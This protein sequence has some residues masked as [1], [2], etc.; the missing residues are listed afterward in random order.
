MH[1][2][3]VF[4]RALVQMNA[5]IKLTKEKCWHSRIDLNWKDRV[6]EGRKKLGDQFKKKKMVKI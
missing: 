6:N 2:R 4:I 1:L 3:M 5:L